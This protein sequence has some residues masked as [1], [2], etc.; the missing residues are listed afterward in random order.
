[1]MEGATPILHAERG[2]M[3]C[4][5]RVYQWTEIVHTQ[6]PGLSKPQATVLAL[7]SVGMVLAQS[8][9]LSAV[10]VYLAVGLGRP[11]LTVRQR[12]RE[13]CYEAGAKRGAQRCT[14]EVGP[15][16]GSLLGW[17]LSWWDGR[18]VALAL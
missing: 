10:S 18:Q 11:E 15:C 12:L 6:L 16:F 9:A 7:W 1:M 2:S 8:C 5:E 4:Q 14:L 17:V 13:F 3:S